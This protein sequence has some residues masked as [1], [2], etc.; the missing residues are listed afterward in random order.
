MGSLFKKKVKLFILNQH[1]SVL[2]VFMVA[3]R[4]ISRPQEIEKCI[5]IF[6]PSSLSR[7]KQQQLKRAIRRDM[8]RHLITPDEYFLYDFAEKSEAEKNNL[9][10]IWKEQ[11]FVL[12]CTTAILPVWF[13]WIKWIP[14]DTSLIFLNA[15]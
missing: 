2:R 1:G 9:L 10:E 13:L 4:L 7:H 11:F 5:S 14:I 12:V 15:K 3:R 6:S 8:Y